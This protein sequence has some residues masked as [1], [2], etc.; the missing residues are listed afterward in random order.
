MGIKNFLTP[1]KTYKKV[2]F[3]L[4]AIL[5]VVFWFSFPWRYPEIFTPEEFKTI[6]AIIWIIHISIFIIIAPFP[7][8]LLEF[9]IHGSK[10]EKVGEEEYK[11]P[12]HLIVL[13]ALRMLG[14]VLF[15][16]IT[17][18]LVSYFLINYL[19]VNSAFTNLFAVFIFMPALVFAI[20]KKIGEHIPWEMKSGPHL[21]MAQ[22]IGDIAFLPVIRW[23]IKNIK[24][25]KCKGDLSEAHY[26]WQNKAFLA[27]RVWCKKCGTKGI[28]TN[29]FNKTLRFRD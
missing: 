5:I 27:F 19:E 4:L 13:S 10:K 6:N 25:P 7:Y 11:I 22:R 12:G 29:T 2:T 21:P 1:D 26:L 23:I 20:F 14:S 9:I 15:V 24:C 28:S 18:V 3:F 17:T 8:I 16:F